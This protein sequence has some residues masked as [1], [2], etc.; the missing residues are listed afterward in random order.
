MP[1]ASEWCD[2]HDGKTQMCGCLFQHG[3]TGLF[4]ISSIRSQHSYFYY[5]ASIF[6]EAH[7]KNTLRAA[8]LQMTSMLAVNITTR[9]LKHW[10]LDEMQFLIRKHCS[11]SVPVGT[12]G[13]VFLPLIAVNCFIFTCWS[14]ATRNKSRACEEPHALLSTCH[15]TGNNVQRSE[16][17]VR[18]IYIT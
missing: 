9:H 1:E 18:Q 8:N 4:P 12:I 2:G 10:A 14:T 5:L 15:S 3:V 13:S 17:A 7:C 6:V 16:S 11:A